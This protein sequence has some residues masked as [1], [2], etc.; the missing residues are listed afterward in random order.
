[1]SGLDA[2]LRVLWSAVIVYV[3]AGSVAI[4]GLIFRRRMERTVLAMLLLALVLHGVAIGLRW[5]RL[6][7]GPF[8]TMFEIL[9]SNVWSLTFVFT[10]AYW[11]IPAIRPTASVV[12]PLIFV[13]LAWLLLSSP[14]EGFFPPTYRTV[15]LYI[16]IAFGKVFLGAVVLAVGLSGVIL[17]RSAG[18]AGRLWTMPDNPSLEELA[19][20][21]LAVGLVFDTLML[22]SGAIWAQDA[23]G[24]YWAWD[25]LESWAF[26]TWLI[27]GFSIHLRVTY[28]PPPAIAAGMVCLVFVMAYLTFFGIPF[29]SKVPHQ[30]AV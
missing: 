30:G 10:L 12:L 14:G 25:P 4:C 16:H 8:I 3:I 26:L 6:G 28:R 13:M 20:R 2:E 5:D 15:W 9:S 11:R 18:I 23:W 22:I 19:Y 17:L 24:R 1:M 7:H 21:F 29:L 27:L